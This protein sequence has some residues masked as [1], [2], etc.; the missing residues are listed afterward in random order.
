[1]RWIGFILVIFQISCAVDE[2]PSCN[3]VGIEGEICKEYQ[4]VFEKYNGVN[5]YEY[6]MN[7][8]L[9]LKI[10]TKGNNGSIEG[11]TNYT[12]N[13]QGLIS[14]LFLEDSKGQLISEK[15][16]L[17]TDLGSIKSEIV[18]GGK[19]KTE[20][21]YYY[22]DGLVRLEVFSSD[23]QVQWIDSIEYFSE[24]NE[25]YRRLRYVDDNLLQITYYEAFVNNVIE[26]R[27]I[28]NNGV[29]ESKKVTL[30]NDENQKIEELMYSKDNI[31][32]NKV[33]YFYQDMK[34]DRIE[35]YN[36]FGEEFEE[37]NYQRF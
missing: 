33:K 21:N 3:G 13:I 7:T 11:V 1:M 35:K 29:T 36:E 6:D 8:G 31:L 17:Y 22:E 10:T 30:F 37:L 32:L 34:V 23:G 5:E 14:S 4:Y 19:I 18:S 15:D 12:Y 24:T 20:H 27:L 25:L 28:N 2:L 9:L 26:E 16:I